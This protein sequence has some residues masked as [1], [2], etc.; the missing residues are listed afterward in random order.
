M[1]IAIVGTGNVGRALAS[2][3]SQAGHQVTLAARDARRTRAVAQELGVRSTDTASDAVGQSD[4]V[5]LAVPFAALADVARQIRDVSSGKVIVD[6]SNP[7]SEDYSGLVTNGGPSPAEDLAGL[8]A[9]AHV[10]KAFNTI[11][12]S[13]QAV[14]TMHGST[15]DALFATD[16]ERA[17]DTIAEL[18]DSLGFRPVHIGG[19][20]GARELEALAFLN[21]RLQL[22]TGGDWRSA[23]VL[24]GAPAAATA[25]P[26]AT[27]SAG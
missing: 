5:V 12:S 21:I 11:F 13:V 7:L 15:I 22:L 20:R 4:V 14:P 19:L 10:V 24:V 26:A 27:A 9:D 16:D 23:F 25:V 6:A 3:F 1:K 18:L 17:R 8:L 2:T